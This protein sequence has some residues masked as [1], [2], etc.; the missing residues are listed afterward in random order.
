MPSTVHRGRAAR[1]APGR[2][3]KRALGAADVMEQRSLSSHDGE[4]AGLGR[5]AMAGGHLSPSDTGGI[6]AAIFAHSRPQMQSEWESCTRGLDESLARIVEGK[7][8]AMIAPNGPVA[9]VLRCL[10]R[11]ELDAHVKRQ[12]RMESLLAGI[13][14][15]VREAVVNAIKTTPAPRSTDQMT[16]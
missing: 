12:P 15:D 7:I 14:K 16:K 5:A 10:V 6:A 3:R 4:E 9:T 8:E 2:R 13:T 11:E 1:E